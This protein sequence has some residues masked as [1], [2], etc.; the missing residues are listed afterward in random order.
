VDYSDVA[1]DFLRLVG[2]AP[3]RPDLAY[4][5]KLARAFGRLPYEN[6]TK[7]IRAE[8]VLDPGE[9]PRMPDLVFADH[10]DLG[11]GGTC[12]SLTHF[13]RT[14]LE[15]AGFEAERVMCDRSYGPNT[16]C[17][18]I[19]PLGRE[20]F[21]V[22]PGY[23]MDEPLAVPRRGESVQR[24]RASVIRLRRLGLSSQ[25]ILITE[26]KGIS[27]LRYRLQDVP[28]GDQ[29]FR[30]LWVDSFDWAMMRHLT[31]SKHVGEG[32]LFMR[33][34]MLRLVN[35]TRKSQDRLGKG[36]AGEVERA[37]GIDSKVVSIA[38]DAV[39]HLRKNYLERK[40]R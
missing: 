12:F 26:R 34:G 15:F 3:L 1:M 36:F 11:T 32:Q 18:L 6:F 13:F 27:K 33:D 20:R 2:I 38:E 24:G 8:E 21:L 35:G 22:D 37:F 39:R 30:G 7:I 40:G 31:A 23:L 9:R 28:V 19:V 4:L 29:L 25:L 14:V 10:V 5:T 17:A 16:H